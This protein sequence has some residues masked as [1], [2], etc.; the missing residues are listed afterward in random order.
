MTE[1]NKSDESRMNRNRLVTISDMKKDTW[2]TLV[3]EIE[4]LWEATSPAI[5]QVGIMRDGTGIIKFVSWEKS[6]LPMMGEGE[7]FYISGAPVSEYNER[8]SIGLV[9]TTKVV[10][11]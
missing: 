10:K 1:H 4:Q 9:K 2:A 5:R 8:L 6:D 7:T 11:L 3:A